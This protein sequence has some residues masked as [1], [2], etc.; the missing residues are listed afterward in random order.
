[1]FGAVR[2]APRGIAVPMQSHAIRILRYTLGNWLKPIIPRPRPRLARR[3][4]GPGRIARS[5]CRSFEVDFRQQRRVGP[6]AQ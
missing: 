6:Q 3:T 5:R 2:R 4:P 1:M